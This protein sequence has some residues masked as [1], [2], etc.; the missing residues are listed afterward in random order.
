MFGYQDTFINFEAFL[1]IYVLRSLEG[2]YNFNYVLYTNPNSKSFFKFSLEFK[3]T[4]YGNT[5]RVDLELESVYTFIERI[6]EITNYSFWVFVL[7]KICNAGTMLDGV[8]NEK[9]RLFINHKAELQH[10]NNC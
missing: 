4:E 9:F 3:F 2:D 7:I 8:L 1:Q 10:V 5:R 6:D